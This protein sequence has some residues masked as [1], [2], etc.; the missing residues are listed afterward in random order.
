[1]LNEKNTLPLSGTRFIASLM[2]F[3]VHFPVQGQNWLS[4][5]T[6]KWLFVNTWFFILSGFVLTQKYFLRFNQLNSVNLFNF[7]IARL[8]KIY[9]LYL[10]LFFIF[11][12][13][14][15]APNIDLWLYVCGLQAW[16]F[17]VNKVIAIDS[18]AWFVSA[19]IFLYLLFPFLIYLSHR[20]KIA[21]SFEK[22]VMT[23]VFFVSILY[24]LA[25]YANLTG[26][27]WLPPSQPK[28]V[29]LWMYFFPIARIPDF[30]L[31][32]I[33][34]I[35][36][37]YFEKK[38]NFP[39]LFWSSMT[40]GACFLILFFMVISKYFYSA[41][42]M[43]VAY[44]VPFFFLIIGIVHSPQAKISRLLSTPALLFLGE[45]SYAFYLVHMPFTIGIVR[46]SPFTI[47][48]A[49]YI[50]IILI[51]ICSALG[52]YELIEKPCQKFILKYFIFPNGLWCFR[53]KFYSFLQKK[54]LQDYGNNPD[55]I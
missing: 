39:V 35:F 15:G 52:F 4:Q 16:T 9:P 43:D 44:L 50:L 12:L 10:C 55:I 54:R 25:N 27:A 24:F 19:I 45:L 47:N 42:F 41:Y 2:I 38:R 23:A 28:S 17:D 11:W 33:A 29:Y 40:Y 36:C 1:M 22:I 32:M 30:S 53:E 8:A 7:Y 26:E 20:L 48:F 6:N 3:I 34:A 18:P 51:I 49:L 21:E 37:F 13:K 5:F 46:S 31:G 14:W